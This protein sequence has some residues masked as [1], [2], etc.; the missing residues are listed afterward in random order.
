MLMP[1]PLGNASAF[2]PRRFAGVSKKEDIMNT[3][4]KISRRLRLVMPALL[5]LFLFL[6]SPFPARLRAAAASLPASSPQAAP[7]NVRIKTVSGGK[8]ILTD[9]R[10]G[11]AVTGYTGIHQYPIGSGNYY[12]FKNKSGEISTTC[13]IKVGSGMICV[14]PTGILWKGWWNNG[15]VCRYYDPATLRKVLG[16]K[17][18][19]KYY[20][21]F[22]MTYGNLK[23]GFLKT[24]GY[25]YYL[26]PKNNGARA[27]GW[28][29]IGGRKYYFGTG[30]RMKT[31]LFT[32]NGKKYYADKNGAQ[33]TGLITTGGARY[34]FDPKT[35]A[36]VTGW[37]TIGKTKYYFDSTGKMV[38]KGFSSDGIYL[39]ADGR[40]LVRSS[41]KKFLQTALKPVGSTMYVWGGGWNSADTGAGPEAVT[42][43]VPSRWKTFF[44]QQN[45][46]YD[47]NTTRYRIHDGL[48]CSGFV[49]WTIY[50][51]FNTVSGRAGYVMLAQNMAR[52]F[53]NMGWGTYASAGTFT[54]FRAGDI[55]SSSSHVYIVIGQCPD[56]SVVLVHSS[57]QGV[58]ING[59]YT[60]S[61]NPSSQAAALAKQYMQKYYPQWYARYPQV[62]R[63]AGYL[64]GFARFRWSLSGKRMMNDPDRYASKDAAA[65]LRDLFGA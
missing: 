18:I 54:D 34:Y 57:P 60:R 3:S 38:K 61:G 31:G 21:F 13:F 44:N 37:Q 7:K 6:V 65:I 23:T 32:Y 27:Y 46:S 15:K 41:L 9:A 40:P 30:G 63:S 24:G 25:T 28:R 56:G 29:T 35:G 20:H 26:N 42:I 5:V 53:S 51:A 64:T 45:A 16:W 2:L 49:G 12:Y 8:K 55:L 58:Q 10:T 4:R 11:K 43:G 47:Y 48:D 59:T 33:K 19:G 50:N 36:A 52:T 14:R 1:I 62:T 22:D 39:D 17:K